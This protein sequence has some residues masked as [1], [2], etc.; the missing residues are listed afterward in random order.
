[1]KIF[2]SPLM[3]LSIVISA[4]GQKY[5]IKFGEIPLEDL[6]MVIQDAYPNLREFYSQVFAK[7]AEQIVLKKK[8]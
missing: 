5:P 7:Q 3:F 6:E 2:L 1:M 8:H 4:A